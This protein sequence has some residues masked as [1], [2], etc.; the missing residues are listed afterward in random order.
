MFTVRVITNVN[1]T[2]EC[3][4]TLTEVT[5]TEGKL[6]STWSHTAQH[7]VLFLNTIAMLSTWGT[8][9]LGVILS[10]LFAFGFRKLTALMLCEEACRHSSRPQEMTFIMKLLIQ[11]IWKGLKGIISFYLFTRSSSSLLLPHLI[12]IECRAT[13]G[14]E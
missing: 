14:Q 5:H 1:H 13:L 12:F 11:T 2:H 6:T 10:E 7:S 9:S 8:Q 3:R 4:V